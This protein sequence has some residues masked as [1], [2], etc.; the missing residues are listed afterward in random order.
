MRSS[1]CKKTAT[2]KEAVKPLQKGHRR[3]KKK[4]RQEE[5][6]TELLWGMNCRR[7]GKWPARVAQR[8]KKAGLGEENH[9]P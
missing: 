2:E 3:K 4:Q 9:Y 7:N 8:K 1:K 5:S 6:L